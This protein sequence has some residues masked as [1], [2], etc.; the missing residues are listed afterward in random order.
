LPAYGALT[1]HALASSALEHAQGILI[2]TLGSRFVIAASTAGAAILAL[3]L[4]T[5]RTVVVS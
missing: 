2:P 5:F 1:A 3:P 4:Y